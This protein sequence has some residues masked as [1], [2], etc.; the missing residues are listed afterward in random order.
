VAAFA[1][2]GPH[3]GV[4]IVVA[5]G[6]V[7]LLAA[8]LALRRAAPLPWGLAAVGAGWLV[9]HAHG[10]SVDHLAPLAGTGLLLAAEL[11][12][13]SIAADARIAV[14]RPVVLLRLATIAATAAGGG[15]LGLLVLGAADVAVPTGVVLSVVGVGAAVGAVALA[16]RLAP[17]S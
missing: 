16:V 10:A 3:P 5:A 15:V 17:G 7:A 13:D 9:A 14:E 2:A 12:Y 4:A 8:G 6:G 11:A 1:N